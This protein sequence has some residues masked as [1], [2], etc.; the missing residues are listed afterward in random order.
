MFR[1]RVLYLCRGREARGFFESGVSIFNTPIQRI[2]PG[3][4]RSYLT[5]SGPTKACSCALHRMIVM[6]P[7][8]QLKHCVD[9]LALI[10]RLNLFRI[11]PDA[12]QNW[13]SG[14]ALLV[15]QREIYAVRPMLWL[16]GKDVLLHTGKPEGAGHASYTG[17]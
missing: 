17:K 2:Q 1:F 7:R 11:L 9:S 15:T 16:V 14:F 3:E 12:P 10:E 8:V 4:R 6:V 5:C 13:V